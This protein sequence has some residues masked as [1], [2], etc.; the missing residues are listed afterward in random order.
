[1][2]NGRTEILIEADQVAAAHGVALSRYHD[3]VARGAHAE[4]LARLA[5][6]EVEVL[7]RRLEDLEV[8]ARNYMLAVTKVGA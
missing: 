4:Q 7:T 8:R 3:F 1:M 5:W 6:L 2:T